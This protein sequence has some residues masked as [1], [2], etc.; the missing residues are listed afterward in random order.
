MVLLD[1]S[2]PA[3]RAGRSLLFCDP[4]R[5]IVAET[6]DEVGAALAAMDAA[7]ADGLHLAGWIAYECAAHFE[8]RLKPQMTARADEPLIWMM[9]TR[10]RTELTPGEAREAFFNA[11]RGNQ[12]MATLEIGD[13]PVSEADYLAALAQ[14]HAYIEAGDVYQINHTF[15]LPCRLEGDALALYERLRASQPVPFGAYIDTGAEHGGHKVLSLSPELFVR[16]QGDRL[17]GKPMKGTAP[18]GLTPADDQTVATELK[19]DE[20]SR[21]ENLMI[22]DLIRNDLSRISRPGSVK[23]TGLFETERYP[24]LWQMTSTIEA[25]ADTALTPSALLAALFPCGS[26]TGAPKVRAMEVIAELEA[27]PRGVYCG[28][29]GHFSPGSDG[30]MD[31]SLN[32]PI[33]TLA[34]GPDG[35]GRLSVGSGVVADSDPAGEYQECLLKA[36]FTKTEAKNAKD[37]SLIETMR[38]DTDCSFD[39]LDAHLARLEASAGYFDFAFDREAVM[40]MLDAHREAFLPMDTPRRVRLLLGQSGAVTVTSTTLVPQAGTGRVCLAKDRARSD[41]VFLFHKTTNRTLYDGA[42][43]RAFKAGFED[44][45]FFNERDELTEGAISTVFIVRDGQWLTPAQTCG[46]L[47]GTFRQALLSGHSPKISEAVIRRAD[48]MAADELYIGNSVRGL[49]RVT[50]VPE[51]L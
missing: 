30:Q 48:L 5:V 19:A 11:R 41:D 51:V 12:H 38:L 1:D 31:W 28:A 20:K 27:A 25:E 6:L 21:A 2:R 14:V 42:F 10:T 7:L 44:I 22:V 50:L 33:R 47:A 24:T 15:P 18:R 26:V 16:R 39:L 37:F 13:S 23:V 49:R 40:A 43:A 17:T 35:H 4:E 46:L 36:R 9:A 8:P 32:V 29:I 34:F 45:L 3:H